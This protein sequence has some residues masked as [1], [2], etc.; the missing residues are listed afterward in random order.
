M[1]TVYNGQTVALITSAK[2]DERL[3][4]IAFL[5]GNLDRWENFK[6]K[7]EGRAILDLIH[8]LSVFVDHYED[9]ARKRA[10]AASNLAAQLLCP[11][12]VVGDFAERARRNG[13][14]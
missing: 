12:A 7:P 10:R 9:A 3:D 6:A 8:D 11:P 5:F 2:I 4:D 1:K 13:A 14:A